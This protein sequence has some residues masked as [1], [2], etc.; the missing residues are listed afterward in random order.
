MMSTT[1]AGN[2]RL[3]N[4]AVPGQLLGVQSMDRQPHFTTATSVNDTILYYFSCDHFEK[5]INLQS[6]L[7]NLFI[8]TVIH[9]MHILADKIYLNTL[10]PEHHTGQHEHG[11]KTAPKSNRPRP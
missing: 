5:L 10:T 6:S 1:A 4:I 3:L 8:K 11:R 2:D 7:L 9:K